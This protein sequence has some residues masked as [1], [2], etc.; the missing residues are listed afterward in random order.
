[1]SLRVLSLL[2]FSLFSSCKSN[3][4]FNDANFGEVRTTQDK[5]FGGEELDSFDSMLF[6]RG[7]DL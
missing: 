4:D 7:G 5:E 2:H 6:G 3:A 1:M